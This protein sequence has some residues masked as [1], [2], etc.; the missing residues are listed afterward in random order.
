MPELRHYDDLGTARFVTFGCHDQQCLLSDI[1]AKKILVSQINNAREKY[2]F[3]IF[4]YVIM[5]DHVHLVIY[6]P[7]G[8]KLGLVMRE[9]KSKTAREYF[10]SIKKEPEGKRV[11][12]QKRCYDHN[13]RSV[14]AV[15]EKIKYC[16]KNPVRRGLVADPGGYIWS[17]FN[18]Y[19]GERD[20]PLEMDEFE[21]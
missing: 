20:V 10:A 4:G 21:R 8:M 7:E 2:R 18:W 14:G 9:I 16:H 6:P 15:W 17:S 11:F 1:S 5:P 12:W 19:Q 13:C 3:K